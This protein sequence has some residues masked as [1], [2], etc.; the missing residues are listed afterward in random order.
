MNPSGNFRPLLLM[1]LLAFLAECPQ[2]SAQTAFSFNKQIITTNE[3]RTAAGFHKDRMVATNAETA[4]TLYRTVWQR[5]NEQMLVCLQYPGI[6]MFGTPYDVT[7]YDSKLKVV[8]KGEITAYQNDT[9]YCLAEVK[10]DGANLPDKMRGQWLFAVAFRNN[11]YQEAMQLHQQKTNTVE[12]I[13]AQISSLPS[14]F[15][16]E[17]VSW[18][19]AH[20]KLKYGTGNLKHAS[21]SEVRWIENGSNILAQAEQSSQSPFTYIIPKKLLPSEHLLFSPPVFQKIENLSPP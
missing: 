14:E 7:V 10:T 6:E 12:S 18:D 21:V 20:V 15:Y 16:F 2:A 5:T 11:R 9:P 1:L 4:F 8:R 3:W 17:L 13:R 19:D